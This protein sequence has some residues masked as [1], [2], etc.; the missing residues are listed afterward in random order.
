MQQS[1]SFGVTLNGQFVQ[2]FAPHTRAMG[3]F[4]DVVCYDL[5][6]WVCHIAK[7]GKFEEGERGKNHHFHWAKHLSR[8]TIDTVGMPHPKVSGLN[9]LI[10]T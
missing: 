7:F 4:L 8:L 10:S 6:H 5:K 9:A 3:R 1:Q 2:M